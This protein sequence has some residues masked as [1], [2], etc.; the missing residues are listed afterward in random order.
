VSQQTG[1]PVEWRVAEPRLAEV[2]EN[3]IDDAG[4]GSRIHVV[5]VPA[6]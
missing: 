6:A 3:M 5:V 4:Y 1:I 2:V